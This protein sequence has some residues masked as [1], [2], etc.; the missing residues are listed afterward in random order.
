[1]IKLLKKLRKNSLANRDVKITLPEDIPLLEK[2][3]PKAVKDELLRLKQQ[4]AGIKDQHC[5]DFF[6]LAFLSILE[7]VSNTSKDGGFLRIID[8]SISPE[9][10]RTRFLDKCTTMI[11]DVIKNNN[12]YIYI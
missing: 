8:R 10:V 3:F 7:S 6:N 5:S 2:A 1:M 9:L 12:I 4:I 11:S